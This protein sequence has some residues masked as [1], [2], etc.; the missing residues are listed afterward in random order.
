MIFYARFLSFYNSLILKALRAVL[1]IALIP[2]SIYSL[3]DVL[4]PNLIIL[5]LSIFLVFEIF[6]KFKVGKLTPKLEIAKN[7]Q[8]P[9]DSFTLLALSTFVTSNNTKSLVENLLKKPQVKF[10]L[11]KANIEKKDLQI[12][13]FDQKELANKAFLVAK[14][15]NGKFVTTMDLIVAYLLLSEESSKLLF[16]K[17]LK[18]EDLEAIL[19][20]ARNRYKKEENPKRTHTY[21]GEGIAEDWVYGWTIETKK[22]MLDLTSEF[23]NKKRNAIGRVNEYNQLL[24]SLYANKSTI[25]V[26]ESGSGK[27]AVVE[28]LARESF[29]GILNGNLFH[30]RILQLMVDAFMAGAKTQG[31][32]EERLDNIIAEVSHSGNIIVY[33]PNIDNI[34]GNSSFNLNISGALIPYVK[35]GKVRIVATATNASYKKF[36]EANPSFLEN[37]SVIKFENLDKS[38]VLEVLFKKASF[39]EE[40][41]KTILTY[42]AI[43]SAYTYANSYAKEKVLPGSAV[44]LLED[45]ANAV[46][47]NK[48]IIVEEKDIEEQI[49]KKV[50]VSVGKP[51]QIE[52]ELLLNLENLMHRRVIGQE[53][54]V[55]AIAEAI[56]RV[57]A[58]L[59]TSQK[60]ISFLFL[61]PTGVGKTETAKALAQVYFGDD[62]KMIRLDM[63]EFNGVDGE[64]RLL[65]AAPGQGDEKGQL[66]ESIYDNPYSMILLDEFEKADLK[67]LDLF[68]QVFDDGRLTDNKGK[69]VSF[70][71]SIIIATSNAAS[72]YIREQ[73][74]KGV[75]IDGTF[76]SQ[77]LEYLQTKQIFKPELLNRFDAIIVFKPLDQNQIKE[78]VKILLLE[79]SQNLKEKD[80]SALFDEKIIAKIVLEGFDN[81]FGARPLR[82]FIQDNIE[83]L[84]AQK[85]LKDEI[86]RGDRIVISTD[87]NNNIV[88]NS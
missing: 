55:S 43:L 27:T 72:E 67:I 79:L 29:M 66:T 64:K 4:Y 65:G 70:V 83:D 61:G 81:D 21:W 9:L 12:I 82:R 39:I 36:V 42:K 13:D 3:T 54:A 48:K 20:W 75:K 25:L 74:S 56:R 15:V 60:P 26:G 8:D 33:I 88:I 87:V 45:S 73:I 16:T 58:G 40:K 76:Y 69:T 38:K 78:V 1:L 59:K 77:L 53:E 71:N 24:E 19:V 35:N 17:E 34:L 84:I 86:K 2:L 37:F 57:R 80:I 41:T 63:S 5:A 49:K 10:I 22:Y 32:L 7:S 51:K 46:S 18:P 52:K 6:F 14:T 31:E 28:H 23:I 50:N 85:M 62:K 44:I 47:L 11:E 30:Q 68:L